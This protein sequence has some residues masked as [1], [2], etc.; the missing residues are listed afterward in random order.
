MLDRGTSGSVSRRGSMLVR[1]PAVG[2]CIVRMDSWRAS[3]RGLRAVG[4]SDHPDGGRII[5]FVPGGVHAA[6]RAPR[7]VEGVC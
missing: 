1:A 2:C 7:A 5:A 6:V 3:R 4:R